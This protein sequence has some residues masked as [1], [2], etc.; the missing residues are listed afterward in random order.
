MF[1]L[2]KLVAFSLLSYA[3]YEF[4]VGVMQDDRPASASSA[5]S[6]GRNRAPSSTG[7]W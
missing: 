7:R 1:G 4:L 3:L 6:R 5:P 2:V